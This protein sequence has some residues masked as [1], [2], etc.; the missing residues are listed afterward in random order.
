MKLSLRLA[1]RIDGKGR[2]S[3]G[4]GAKPSITGGKSGPLHVRWRHQQG[5]VHGQRAIARTVRDRQ[6]AETVGHEH[7][8]RGGRANLALER[9]HPFPADRIEPVTLGD[10]TKIGIGLLPEALPV[11]GT[12]VTPAGDDQDG[13][14]HR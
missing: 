14:T 3:R 6:A 7:D 2:G 13:R 8:G 11:L 10:A 12:G 1:T 4:I 5:A 9:L